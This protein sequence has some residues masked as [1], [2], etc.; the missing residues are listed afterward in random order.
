MSL[1]SIHPNA[2]QPP[3]NSSTDPA[4]AWQSAATGAA[5]ASSNLWTSYTGQDGITGAPA[6]K[7]WVEL[8]AITQDAYV[9]FTRTATTATTASTGSII[10]AGQPAVMYYIDPT[11]DLFLDHIAPAG[12][13]TIKWRVASQIGE[14][15]RH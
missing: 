9:R 8:E 6:G 13:G 10:K 2:A 11:K 12:A 14:R 5:A 3:R 1:E 4:Y 7:V 15:I